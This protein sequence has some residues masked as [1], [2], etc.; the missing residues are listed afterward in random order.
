[1]GVFHVK[2]AFLGL[3]SLILAIIFDNFFEINRFSAQFRIIQNF[4]QRVMAG[5]KF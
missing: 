4:E 1:M 2:W 5:L 3:F